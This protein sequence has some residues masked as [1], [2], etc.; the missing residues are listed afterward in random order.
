LCYRYGATELSPI[1]T[2]GIPNASPLACGYLVP[3]TQMKVVG[4]ENTNLNKNLGPKEIG[5]IYIR[6]PQV[7]K[8][9]YK[10]SKATADTMDKD[11]FKS[12]DLG[13]FTEN[14][15]IANFIKKISVKYN[16]CSN[17]C[18]IL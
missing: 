14:G 7:M 11:W 15:K 13:Y 16:Y 9:Y 8:G 6:G 18:E 3:N 4:T 5:E 1:C 12:G 10:N 17:Y 2:H